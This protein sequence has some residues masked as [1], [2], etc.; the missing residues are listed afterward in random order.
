MRRRLALAFGC[1]CAFQVAV[2]Y[3]STVFVRA[4]ASTGQGFTIKR[5]FDCL[6]IVPAHVVPEHTASITVIGERAEAASASVLRKYQDDLDV[7]QLSGHATLC[8]SDVLPDVDGLPGVFARAT[9]GFLKIRTEDGAVRQV[10]VNI[11][12]Y[13]ETRAAINSDKRELRQGMSGAMVYL[14]NHEAGMLLTA[15]GSTGSIRRLDSIWGEIAGLLVPPRLSLDILR[16]CKTHGYQGV[17]NKDGTGYG[18]ACTPG[19]GIIS[20]IDACKEQHGAQYTA[21][22]ASPAPGKPNDWYCVRIAE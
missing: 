4:D 14:D 9:A 11:S 13:D 15:D 21:R 7:L 2:A 19:D 12:Q 20:G 6:V 22:L 3:A 1:F 8:E 5:E 16:Y 10:R 17:R 18:W